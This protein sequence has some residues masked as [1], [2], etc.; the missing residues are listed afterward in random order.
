[1]IKKL[2]VSSVLVVSLLAYAAPAQGA[3]KPMREKGTGSSTGEACGAFLCW[4]LE[5]TANG[6]PIKDG[7]FRGRLR[8]PDSGEYTNNSGDSCRP[9]DG[10]ATF[11]KGNNRIRIEFEGEAC[12]LADKTGESRLRTFGRVTGG[13]G[14]YENTKGAGGLFMKFVFAKSG[15]ITYQWDGT[16]KG[17]PCGGS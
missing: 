8:I 16:I 1:M 9:A 15:T 2:L 3:I 7:S 6:N 12:I 10:R 14:D 13:T 4:E 5:G 11:R 17:C